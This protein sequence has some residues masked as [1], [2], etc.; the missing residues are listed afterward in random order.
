MA[1][2]KSFADSVFSQG[3]GR[4][5]RGLGLRRVVRAGAVLVVVPLALLLGLAWH[6]WELDTPAATQLGWLILAVVLLL[7]ACVGL[8]GWLGARWVARPLR[9]LA[10]A[11]RQIE[12]GDGPRGADLSGARLREIQLLHHGLQTMWN[13]LERRRN[14]RD[15]ALLASDAARQQMQ[16]VLDH[17][18]EGFMILD[19]SWQ[20]TFCNQRG[21]QLVGKAGNLV[22]LPFWDLFPDE[23][24]RGRAA[25]CQREVEHGRSLV[26]EDFHSRYRR[27]FEMRFFPSPVGIG[28][29]VRDVTE[30]RK[31]MDELVE[32]ERR[33]REL[34]E[35]NPNVM[36][37][38]DTQTL[39][40]LAVN[41]AAVAHYGYCRE[42][43]L[44]MCITDIR[45]EDDRQ[46]LEESV[47]DDE[48]PGGSLHDEARIWRHVTK[49]GAVILV[50][51]ARHP[52]TFQG[53]PARL[54]MVNDVTAR[55]LGESRLRRR[56]DKLAAAHEEGSRQLRA[57]S[58]LVAGYARLLGEEVLPV[59]S[60]AQ[61]QDVGSVLARQA[62]RVERL[63]RDAQ[64]LAQL[65]SAPFHAAVVDLSALAQAGIQRLRLADPG[66]RVH[67]EIEPGL[68]CE[69]DVA[70][71]KLAV[72]AL[73]DN[74]WKF[75]ARQASPWIRMG[76]LE[77]SGSPQA[78]LFVSDNGIGFDE[79]LQGRAW[80]PFERLHSDAEY[81][82]DGLGLAVVRGVV[83]RHGGK[84]W[85]HSRPGQGATFCLELAARREDDSFR[86]SE[87]VIDS[88]PLDGD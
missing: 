39:R 37:I 68:A 82:G 45:P 47:A 73:L 52:I 24:E 72:D 26:L 7:A 85:A 64:R 53:R 77:R 13:G 3:A 50:E 19:G 59:L 58:N 67:V 33:Y 70:L 2:G 38:F 57:A 48:E 79:S 5:V 41:A 81:S 65:P 8:A 66:R 61:S 43:F 12:R 63:L 56:H 83:A 6:A 44:E 15:V 36:W 69:G 28:V 34:F 40:F 31:M 80:L 29:F 74:A 20:L 1:R 71:L 35:V 22:G 86:V 27:W 16:S 87:V 51:V 88:M 14:E 55:L 30:R 25:G 4:R 84:A 17:M 75:T 78:S 23:K 60:T 54:V 32:R 21:A 11:M 42:E 10:L 49:E 9:E 62:R 18:D 76:R 46:A